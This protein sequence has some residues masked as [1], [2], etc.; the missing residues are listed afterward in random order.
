[1]TGWIFD[2]ATVS[3]SLQVEDGTYF[4]VQNDNGTWRAFYVP[5]QLGRRFPTDQEAMRSVEDYLARRP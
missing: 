3:Y 4:V 1:M 5:D 2:E